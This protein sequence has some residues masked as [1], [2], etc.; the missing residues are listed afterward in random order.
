MHPLA[1]A[2]AASF[3][4]TLLEQ[5]KHEGFCVLPPGTLCSKAAESY[6]REI[7]Q[8]FHTPGRFVPNKVEFLLAS[9]PLQLVKE[10]IYECD[11]HSEASRKGMLAFEEL[12]SYG[13]AEIATVL[14]ARD[15]TLELTVSP[16][17]AMKEHA[18]VKLQVN[19]GGGSFPWHTDNPQ[20]P[21]KR[22][23]TLAVYLTLD[24]KPE[25]G[26]ELVL[27]PFLGKAL[28][29]PPAFVTMV[30]FRSDVINHRTLPTAKAFHAQAT[31]PRECFTIW[32][33]SEAVNREEDVFLRAKHL[34]AEWI[35]HLMSNNPQHRS[36]TRAVYEEEYREALIDCFGEGSQQTLV[37]LKVHDAHLAPLLRNPALVKFLELLRAQKKSGLRKDL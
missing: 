20:P 3:E 21:N 15:S 27:Q 35:P 9:G 29:I 37:S 33:D 25:M 5:W 36:I 26:G 13:L 28:V 4:G 8:S 6:Q 11:L 7:S 24:W 10:H 12:F 2:V 1:A 23:V 30:L 17:A 32:F 18:T 16:G 31:R 19:T 34:T 14:N 22:K